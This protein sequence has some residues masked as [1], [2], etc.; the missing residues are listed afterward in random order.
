MTFIVFLV[1]LSI[2]V[3]IHEF[4]HF[5]VA[6]MHGIRVEEFGWGL[7]PRVWGKKIGETIYSI[8]LLPFGGFVR[9]TGEDEGA[10]DE[11][12]KPSDDTQ[13][14][15]LE[16][17]ESFTDVQLTEGGVREELIIEETKITSYMD[18]TSASDGGAA[19]VGDQ[20]DPRS[21]AIKS[22]GQ[23]L[24][25]LVAGVVMNLLLAFVIFYIYLFINSFKT[26]AIP[27]F[28]DYNFRFGKVTRLNTMILDLVDKFPATESGV[29]V[30][31]MLESVD[32]KPVTNIQ[33]IRVA[34]EGKA[35]K[36]VS[37]V[38]TSEKFG[39]RT[40]QMTPVTNEEGRA[41]IGVYIG[42]AVVIDY[43]KTFVSKLFSAPMHS[44]NVMGF[45]LNGLKKIFA[46][47]YETK[48]IEPVS[49]SV[50][51][52]V[53][54]FKIVDNILKEGGKNSILH[55][56]DFAGLMSLSLAFMNILPFPALDGG[57]AVF[58]VIEGVFGRRISPRIEGLIHRVGMAIL[59]TLIVVITIKDLIIR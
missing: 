39:T 47:S 46:F 58:V 43:G 36:K 16:V 37:V 25:V 32:G 3:L 53:G 6:K 54:M 21:F 10:V 41:S 55:L 20:F 11:E 15:Q 24:S 42:D 57:R 26:P 51:G 50:A 19:I 5:I 31:E 34:L 33:D 7:P 4:G 38:L 30:G 44:Y 9:L 45:S 48:S 23:R 13:G 14:G 22:P 35:D 56:M 1:I 12:P 49:R 18:A 59:L 17:S 40:V 2:L 29:E 52:P 27:L 28:F 8:N